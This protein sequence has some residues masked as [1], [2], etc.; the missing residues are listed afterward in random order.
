MP[1]R[2]L[3]FFLL[4]CILGLF[5]GIFI[6]ARI[7]PSLLVVVRR[8]SS[9]RVSTVGSFLTAMLTFLIAAYAVLIHN[10][11]LLCLI[12]FLRGFGFGCLAWLSVRAFGTAAWLVQPLLQFSD[13]FVLLT[14]ILFG[15]WVCRRKEQKLHWAVVLCIVIAAAVSAYDYLAVSPFLASLLE[16]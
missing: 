5:A 11:L 8:A 12:S 6:A 13:G 2:R 1:G 4:S 14:Y 7:D 10:D 16:F 3:M 9:C 15:I